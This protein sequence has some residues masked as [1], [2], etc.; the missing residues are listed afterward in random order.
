[1][2]II[3]NSAQTNSVKVNI[4]IIPTCFGVNTLWCIN[5]ETCKS[6]FNINFYTL[7]SASFGIINKN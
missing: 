1:M 7:F 6:N 4:K 2:C 3:P 5:N